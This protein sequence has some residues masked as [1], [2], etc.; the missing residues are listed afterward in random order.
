[1]CGENNTGEGR[2]ES[3]G[4]LGFVESVWPEFICGEHHRAISDAFDRIISGDL[5]RLIVNLPPRYSKSSFFSWL[6]PAYKFGK[7]PDQNVILVNNRQD[8]AVMHGLKVMRLIGSAEY[9]EEFPGVSIGAD[10]ASKVGWR[11][12]NNRGHFRSIG[13]GGA[14]CGFGSDL[15][16]IDDPLAWSGDEGQVFE[17]FKS[18]IRTKIMPGGAIVIA[19]TRLPD[20]DLT[21]CLLEDSDDWEILN[22]S[23]M[24]ESGD[25]SWPGFWSTEELSAI[26]EDISGQDWSSQYMGA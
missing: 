1:M 16:I 10:Q 12:D 21:D 17:W 6:L 26:R 2:M 19:E 18:C 3:K 13:V 24:T 22:F 23:A 9:Q 25:S 15:T 20:G 11:L 14:L 4:F 8:L 7:R 5:K